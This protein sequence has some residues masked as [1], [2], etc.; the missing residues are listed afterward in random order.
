[1]APLKPAMLAAH[2]TDTWC[3]LLSTHHDRQRLAQV[4]AR[5]TEEAFGSAGWR[6]DLRLAEDPSSQA[7]IAAAERHESDLIVVGAGSA[8]SRHR[9]PLSGVARAI[10]RRARCSVLI[11]RN[12][13]EPTCGREDKAFSSVQAARCAE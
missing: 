12:N 13:G 8:S 11:T 6:A 2:T 5:E 4:L 3:W 10:L 7:V 9:S 1:M